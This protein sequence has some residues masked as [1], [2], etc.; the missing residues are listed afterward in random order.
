MS[1]VMRVFEVLTMPLVLLI[2]AVIYPLFYCANTWGSF[3]E[4][5]FYRPEPV[6]ACPVKVKSKV[7]R[8]KKKT[9]K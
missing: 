8:K 2:G 4:V 3:V 7:K 5:F 6:H 9:S 1:Y